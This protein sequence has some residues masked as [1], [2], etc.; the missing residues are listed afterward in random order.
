MYWYSSPL[1]NISTSFSPE[2]AIWGPQGPSA[3]NAGK[4]RENPGFL[5]KNPSNACPF[6]PPLFSP[7]LPGP[8]FPLFF[9]P[10]S[11]S[12]FRPFL[13]PFSFLY[14]LSPYFPPPLLS[15]CSPFPPPF[16]ATPFSPLCP[17]PSLFLHI[18]L[19][20]PRLL[21]SASS[22]PT[23]LIQPDLS[24]SKGGHSQP[25]GSYLGV[26]WICL[27]CVV[28][29]YSNGFRQGSQEII[30]EA[31]SQSAR[32]TKTRQRKQTLWLVNFGVHFCVAFLGP[33]SF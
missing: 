8:L 14:P 31:C 24:R 22:K 2:N 26:S 23:Q 9:P 4:F 28:S 32:S 6:V 33:C 5:L 10:L 21:A 17:P 3:G 16:F 19:C 13:A 18:C 1:S 25:R 15:L 30:K 12:P 7:F 11:P 20:C 27:I 29:T